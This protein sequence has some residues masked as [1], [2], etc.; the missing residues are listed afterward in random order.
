MNLVCPSHSHTQLFE[1]RVLGLHG[2]ACGP[3]NASKETLMRIVHVSVTHLDTQPTDHIHQR[4]T[5]VFV[6]LSVCVYRVVVITAVN[7]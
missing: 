1:R 4:I 3:L 2:Y 7:T 6:C 5:G